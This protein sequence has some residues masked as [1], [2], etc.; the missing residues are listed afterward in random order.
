MQGFEDVTISW[1]GED[2]TIP[3]DRQLMLV[4]KIEDALSQDSG[5]QAISF[6]MRAEGPPYSRLAMAFG[7]ALRYAGADVSDDEVY[8]S[9]QD[10]FAK[11][12]NE[13]T[14]KVQGAVMALLMIVSPPMGMAIAKV[15]EK[16]SPKKKKKIAD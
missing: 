10:D 8:L 14:M 6:L 5:K 9:I 3:A 12:K 4:A 11:S 15:T 16:K 7:A 13:V 2:Y 1:K